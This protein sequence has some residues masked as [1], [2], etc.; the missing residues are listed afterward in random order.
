M[1]TRLFLLFSTVLLW[2]SAAFAQ[3]QTEPP[4]TEPEIGQEYFIAHSSGLYLSNDGDKLKI[5]SGGKV[6]DQRFVFEAI[7]GAED[8]YAIKSVETGRYM[9][10]DSPTGWT[11]LWVDE[12]SDA[13]AQYTIELSHDPSY[14]YI[15]CLGVSGEDNLVGTDQNS[16]GSGVYSNKDAGDGKRCWRLEVAEPGFVFTE[17]LEN[18]IETAEATLAAASIGD[19]PGQYPQSAADALTEAINDAKAVLENPADQAAVNNAADTLNGAIVEFNNSLTPPEG[20]YIDGEKRVISEKT[21]LHLTDRDPLRNGA[22]VDLQS[23]DAWLFFDSVKPSIAIDEYVPSVT[24]NGKAIEPGVNARVEMY[25]SGTVII[26]QADDFVA[27]EAWTGENYTG[28]KAEYVVEGTPYKELGEFDNAIKSIKLKRGYMA[29]LANE[30]NGRGYSKV[31]IADS[32]DLEIPVLQSELKGKISFIRCFRWHYVSKKGWCSSGSGWSNELLLTNSTWYYSWSA[33]KYTT[34]DAEYT[35]IKQQY[36]W[37]GWD[38]INGKENV[39]HLLGF[40]EPDRPEQANATVAQAIEQWP[41]M[42][43]SGLRLGTP[44]IADNLNWLY[45]F[46]DEAR[47]RNYRVDFVAVHAYWGGPG[48]AQNVVDSEGNVS[49]DRWYEVLKGIHDRTGLPIWITEWNNGANW[50]H[51]NEPWPGDS[52]GNAQKARADL[53]KIVKLFD[54]TP[55]IE[56]Y[57]IYNWVGDETAIVIGQS[58]SDNDGIM[59]NNGKYTAGGPL[60]QKLSYAGEFY[61]AND[62]PLA[63]N[64]EYAVEP[65]WQMLAPSLSATFDPATTSVNVSWTDYMGEVT[66]EYILERK[67]D[68]G[69]WATLATGK[70]GSSSSYVDTDIASFAAAHKYTYRLRIKC[71]E[72]EAVSNEVLIDIPVLPGSGDIRVAS[73][74]MSDLAWKYFYFD[75][76]APYAE[77]PAVIFGNFASNTRTLLSYG[78]DLVEATGFSFRL[79]PWLYQ[80]VESMTREEEGSFLAAKT[81]NYDWG[82]LPV[83][84]GSN[85]GGSTR[86]VEVTFEQPFDQVPVVFV[87]PQASA[88]CPTYPRI[89]NVSETG[90]EV[91]FT[92][93]EA[94]ADVDLSRMAISYFAVVPGTT[95]LADGMVVEVGRTADVVGELSKKGDIVFASDFAE[96][97]YFLCALQTS[98][99]ELTAALRYSDLTADGVSVLKQR[100]KSSGQ[101]A[102]AATDV[103]GYIAVSR[104]TSSGINDVAGNADSFRVYPT[105]TDGALNV[106]AEEGTSLSVY[107]VNGVLVMQET[108]AGQSLDVSGLAAGIYFI[109]NSAGEVARFIVK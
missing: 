63:Y 52:A 95:T 65:F 6:T 86:W 77:A 33:D 56:R 12:P 20:T 38:E 99:D 97:P 7:D 64:S 81:G 108:Y 18:A 53:E 83:E 47:A 29:T 66:D 90:F 3:E 94:Q 80:G 10:G 70:G 67:T 50:T 35:P 92:K 19:E 14:I 73:A 37:P 69:E 101:A 88:D 68:D 84:A 104:S 48:G 87:S 26:P 74:S 41:E 39:T 82:T 24:V 16:E 21:D 17:S 32:E 54:E 49:I 13:L 40:N 23:P 59:D 107:N 103:V 51:G 78:M 22:T 76:D 58:D 57:S 4:I 75:G 2:F 91:H 46:M 9:S 62:A 79:E 34:E 71:G 60:N 30:S 25:R 28:E 102:T 45:E 27:L 1:E 44:A 11:L 8:T 72:D 61:A 100:E 93:E 106:V 15:H 98:N 89:R 96:A 109:R 85:D 31:F 5:M 105:V 36:W 55:W 42:M 43:E